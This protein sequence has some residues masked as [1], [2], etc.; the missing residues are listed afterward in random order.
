MENGKLKIHLCTQHPVSL[1]WLHNPNYEMEYNP[2]NITVCIPPFKGNINNG[3][4]KHLVSVY[5]L[6][7]L[8][9]IWNG[10]QLVKTKLNAKK[11]LRQAKLEHNVD[12]T[13]HYIHLTL[14][15]I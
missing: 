3:T 11:A 8:S 2:R 6:Y 5:I 9:T 1:F 14:K 13:C 10:V 12:T 4:N 7:C 15:C